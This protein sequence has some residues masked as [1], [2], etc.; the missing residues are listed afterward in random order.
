[1]ISKDDIK[2]MAELSVIAVSDEE[3]EKITNEIGSVL[4]YVSDISKLISK[5]DLKQKPKMYNVMRD[6]EVTNKSGEYTKDIL[7]NAPKTDG[8]YIVVKKII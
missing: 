3:L 2:K 6:D 7:D 8:E 1:M 4:G 5:E